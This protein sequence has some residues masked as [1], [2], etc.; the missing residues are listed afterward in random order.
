MDYDH[1]GV[2]MYYADAP[3]SELQTHIVQALQILQ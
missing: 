1:Y 3:I 2:M